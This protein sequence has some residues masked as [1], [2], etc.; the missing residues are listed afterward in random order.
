MVK[1]TGKNKPTQE[2]KNCSRIRW[3]IA[4]KI[5]CCYL[6]EYGDKLKNHRSYI[7]KNNNRYAQLKE[8]NLQVIYKYFQ[9]YNSFLYQY[10]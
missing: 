2:R 5:K 6:R 1:T 9:Y 8:T 3:M 10:K 7:V 4:N